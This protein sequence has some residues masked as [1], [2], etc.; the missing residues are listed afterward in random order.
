MRYAKLVFILLVPAIA[1]MAADP[2][3]GTWKLNPAK[4]KF[5]AGAPYQEATITIAESGSDDDVA[6]KG[7]A[8]NGAPLSLHYTQ[9]ANGGIGKIVEGPFDAVSGKLLNA[10]ER[11]TRYS[12]GGKVSYTVHAKVSKDGKTLTIASKGTN[13]AGQAVDGVTVYEK[14]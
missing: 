3:V 1:L 8:A 4:S 14:Q 11:E 6:L 5:K 13:A 2:F 7:T 9:P 12:K 10:R